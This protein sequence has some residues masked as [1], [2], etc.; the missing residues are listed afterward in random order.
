MCSGG[1]QD[2]KRPKTQLPLLKS[3]EQ[4][5]GTVRA[6]T[7]N[8]TKGVGTPSRPA[9]QLTPGHTL[10]LIPYKEAVPSPQGE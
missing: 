2:T 6:R 7:F 4:K 1:Q 3:Q 5:Q 10:T 9:L 8:I